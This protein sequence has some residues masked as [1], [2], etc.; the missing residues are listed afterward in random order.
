VHSFTRLTNLAAA[1][2]DNPGHEFVM[3]P[4][5]QGFTW[6]VVIGAA[7]GIVYLVF[8]KGRGSKSGS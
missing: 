4:V 8:F 5:G 7:I 1:Q 6:A 2:S 3:S